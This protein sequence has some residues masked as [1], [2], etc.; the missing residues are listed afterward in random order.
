M[1]R[2]LVTGGAGNVGGALAD[3]LIESKKYHVVILDNFRTGS[4]SKLPSKSHENWSLV[5]GDANEFQTLSD[6]FEANSFDYVF[7]YAALVGVD[8]TLANPIDVLRDIQGIN[9]VCE[10]CVQHGIKRVFFSSSSE[11]YGEPLQ[12][13]QN[14]DETPMNAIL[15]YAKVKS[16]GESFFE[17]YRKERG[18]EYT[19]FR[20]FNTYGPKQSQDFVIGKFI[21]SALKNED[22]TVIGDGSQTRTFCHIN[23]NLDV[24]MQCLENDLFVNEIINLGNNHEISILELAEFV[25]ETLDSN[26]KVVHLPARE[27]GDMNRRKPDLSKLRKHYKKEMIDL[28]TGIKMVAEAIKAENPEKFHTKKVLKIA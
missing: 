21:W 4:K 28:E 6:L 26:S 11:V 3:R 15:P 12:I 22:V 10:L 19:I 18:L 5:V 2:I 8:R 27:E 25:I 7:H 1:K 16:V 24:T 14:E 13:P 9:H 20:F 23:D 17:A